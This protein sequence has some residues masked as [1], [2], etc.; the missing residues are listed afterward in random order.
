MGS[1]LRYNILRPD[2]RT[3]F[4]LINCFKKEL[5]KQREVND[6]SARFKVHDFV[7][8]RGFTR[9]F[10]GLLHCN[11]LME[12]VRKVTFVALFTAAKGARG[13]CTRSLLE[14]GPLVIS[15]ERSSLARKISCACKAGSPSLAC[16]CVVVSL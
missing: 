1:P 12:E 11:L 14:G 4:L 2:D 15:G 7:Q 9:H 6:G 3:L 5:R 16:P 10:L 8:R 13:R